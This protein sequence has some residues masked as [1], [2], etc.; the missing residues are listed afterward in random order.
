MKICPTPT[1]KPC[2]FNSAAYTSQWNTVW[3][4]RR[5]ESIPKKRSFGPSKTLQKK[6]VTVAYS[7]PETLRAALD[8]DD[9]TVSPSGDVWAL[10]VLLYMLLTGEHPFAPDMSVSDED[11]AENVMQDGHSGDGIPYTPYFLQDLPPPALPKATPSP[12]KGDGE[13]LEISPVSKDD[14]DD[15]DSPLEEGF[16]TEDDDG[17]MP[18]VRLPPLARDLLAKMLNRNTAERPSAQDILQHPWLRRAEVDLDRANATVSGG[19]QHAASGDGVLFPPVPVPAASEALQM[20]WSGRRRLKGCLLA[21][22]AG[23]V[24][25]IS[26]DPN[27]VEGK[28]AGEVQGGFQ[29]QMQRR[30]RSLRK[31]GD[32]ERKLPSGGEAIREDVALGSSSTSRDDKN[33]ATVGDFLA[34]PHASEAFIGS[35]TVACR[36]IDRGGKGYITADDLAHVMRL[37]GE[38]V[39]ASEEVVSEMMKAVD[40]DPSRESPRVTYEQMARLVPPLCPARKYKAGEELYKEG[41]LDPTFYLL[42]KGVVEFSVTTP[43]GKVPLQTQGPGKHEMMSVGV[44]MG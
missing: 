19:L 7:P 42:R 16:R 25:G 6:R 12:R 31:E 1:R 26:E 15:D 21:V 9:L 27:D 35:R 3:Y 17:E 43:G 39:D 8:G 41:D 30:R 33:A 23:L 2:A 22:M 10:G 11:I 40:G 32:F 4:V 20:F 29:Q 18:R 14:D 34:T 38:D 24:D 36:M 37:M 28:E 13:G 44:E 5:P